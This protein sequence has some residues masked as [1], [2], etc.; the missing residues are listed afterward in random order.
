MHLLNEI[1]RL[2]KIELY[3]L[4]EILRLTYYDGIV[5]LVRNCSLLFTISMWIVIIQHPICQNIIENALVT[6]SV[7][8]FFKCI[9]V[10]IKCQFI[11]NMNI[12]GY[13]NEEKI[14]F[15]VVNN[16]LKTIGNKVYASTF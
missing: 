2:R 9:Y 4:Y 7:A 16:N 8:L 11:F 15:V 1:K 13:F 3:H 14:Q 12:I 10:I 5:N 6:I